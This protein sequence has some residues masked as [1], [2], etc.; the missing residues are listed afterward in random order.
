MEGDDESR[1]VIIDFGG[2]GRRFEGSVSGNQSSPLQAF[3][4]NREWKVS[5]GKEHCHLSSPNFKISGV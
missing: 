1:T 2:E 3:L 4:Y 5:L